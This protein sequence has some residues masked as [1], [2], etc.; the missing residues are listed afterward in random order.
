VMHFA[1][2]IAYAKA[3]VASLSGPA[4]KVQVSISGYRD[5]NTVG[6]YPGAV[7]SKITVTAIELW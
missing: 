5:T 7:A 2:A 1:A 3:A 6:A 4:T